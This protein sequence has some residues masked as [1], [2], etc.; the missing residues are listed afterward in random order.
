M[1]RDR[2]FQHILPVPALMHL[3]YLTHIRQ[4]L[5]QILFPLRV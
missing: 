2:L 3:M 5:W 1:Y 4:A